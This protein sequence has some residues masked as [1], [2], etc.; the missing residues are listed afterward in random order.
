[1]N[2]QLRHGLVP[3]AG[4]GNF[5]I[6]SCDLY[7]KKDISERA[8]S[9]VLCI[10]HDYSTNKDGESEEPKT[11]LFFDGEYRVVV[12]EDEYSL[13]AEQIFENENIS[14]AEAEESIR[15]RYVTDEYCKLIW[16]WDPLKKSGEMWKRWQ[17]IKLIVT[18]SVTI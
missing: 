16:G 1:M 12:T 7:E 2:I 15:E 8:P 5:W 9:V 3:E 17:A 10:K 6:L 4:A 13:M 11:L 18:P 14:M